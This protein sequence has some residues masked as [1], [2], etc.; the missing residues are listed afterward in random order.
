MGMQ[1]YKTCVKAIEA[2]LLE[3][4]KHLL[5]YHVLI[6]CL[7]ME[8]Y[9]PSSWLKRCYNA[10][11]STSFTFVSTAGDITATYSNSMHWD[12]SAWVWARS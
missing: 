1:N 8:K 5:F 11:P 9:V 2:F 10:P 6:Y 3:C 4:L 7:C 12:F